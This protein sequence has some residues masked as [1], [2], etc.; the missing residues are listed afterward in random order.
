MFRLA[1][2]HGYVSESAFLN[3]LHLA[4]ATPDLAFRTANYSRLLHCAILAHGCCFSDDFRTFDAAALAA[5]A[6]SAIP[7]EGDAP[8]LSAV[9]GLLVL[10]D[11]FAHIGSPS[12]GYLV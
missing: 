3:D 4:T 7:E 2:F 5:H 8:K 12:F 6:I 9:Q 10:S 11:H 1:S